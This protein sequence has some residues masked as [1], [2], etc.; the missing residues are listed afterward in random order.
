MDWFKKWMGAI[1]F[2]MIPTNMYLSL[3]KELASLHEVV[4]AKQNDV[5]V[6]KMDSNVV[7]EGVDV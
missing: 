1:V 2:S 5:D 6:E 4:N 7:P 3:D